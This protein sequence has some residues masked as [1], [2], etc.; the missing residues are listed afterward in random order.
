M[1]PACP[2]RSNTRAG[3][4]T[5]RPASTTTGRG[6]ISR[7]CATGGEPVDLPTGRFTVSKTDLVLPARIPVT[8][9]RFY[10]NENPVVGILGL[11]WALDPYET[12]LL[13]QS[14]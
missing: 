11:G 1:G 5:G 8:I 13:G 10:R 9:Q 6:T 12:M 4:T 2:T 7:G 14:A 3:R